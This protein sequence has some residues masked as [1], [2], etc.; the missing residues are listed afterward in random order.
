MQSTT[1]VPRRVALASVA[2]VRYPVLAFIA[3]IL[4]LFAAGNLSYVVMTE[5][6]DR[7]VQHIIPQRPALDMW[8]RW[9]SFWYLRIVHNGYFY[10]DGKQSSVAFFPL[11]PLLI[12]TVSPLLNNN[13]LIAG[14]LISNSAFL[15]ALL[16]LYKLTE[17]EFDAQIAQRAVLL[18]SIFP[19]AIFFRV[20]Y[21]ESLFILLALC[22]FYCARKGRL[23]DDWR[24]WVAAGAFGALIS[25]TRMTGITLA[26]PIALEWMRAHGWTLRTTLQIETWRTLWQAVR[27]NPLIIAVLAMVPLGLLAYMGYQWY[28]F[29]DPLVFLRTQATWH[30]KLVGPFQA[31]HTTWHSILT[32]WHYHW[33]HWLNLAAFFSAFGIGAAAWRRLGTSYGV[34]CFA[35]IMIPI[36]STTGSMS[37]FVVVLFPMFMI[38][39]WWL[40]KRPKLERLLV[41]GFTVGMAVLMM[42]FARWYFIA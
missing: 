14:L 18:A 27:R 29:G 28:Q 8:A 10:R 33:Y 19:T 30:Q 35:T 16:V 42:L 22:I 24:W 13:T 12:S 37:R 40:H 36:M 20:L 41:G 25:S 39:A 34:F 11:Y 6:V 9:D 31:I 21:T 4:I 23:T 38:L 7:H 15:A 26:A 17:E 5:N 2:W 1:T 3:S 32:G